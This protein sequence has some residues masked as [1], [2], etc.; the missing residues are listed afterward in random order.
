MTND[1]INRTALARKISAESALR[2]AGPL[3]AEKTPLWDGENPSHSLRMARSVAKPMPA[4]IQ[5]S[6]QRSFQASFR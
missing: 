4:G 6:H 2:M 3:P 5:S 1:Q